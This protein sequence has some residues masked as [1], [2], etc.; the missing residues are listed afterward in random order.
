MAQDEHEMLAFLKFELKF[1][2]M[3]ATG[4]LPAHLGVLPTS[5]KTHPLVS[6]WAIPLAHIRAANVC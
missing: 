1:E 2:K 3:E 4:A 6:I 5:S